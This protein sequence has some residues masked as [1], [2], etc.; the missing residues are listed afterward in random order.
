MKNLT[1]RQ[2]MII[3]VILACLSLAT[4]LWVNI[5]PNPILSLRL[6]LGT[7]LTIFMAF[8]LL[9]WRW[10]AWTR[11]RTQQQTRQ[12]IQ[13]QT[14]TDRRRFLHRLDHE[15]KNPLTT[16]RV[17]VANLRS[18]PDKQ[19]SHHA[20]TTIENE[21]L[22]LSTFIGDLRKLADLEVRPL[23]QSQV[24][25]EKLLQEVV[26]LAEEQPEAKDRQLVLHPF[27]QAPGPLP[28]IVGDHDLLFLALFNL[29]TN[30]LKFT[31]PGDRIEVRASEDGTRV[32]LE[33]ADTGIGIPEIDMPHVW[34]ELYRGQEAGATP[35][36]GLGLALVK[37][38]IERHGGQV[39]L[40]S[41]EAQGTVVTI[42]LPA[43][44]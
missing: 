1:R 24:I 12:N 42:Q 41:P 18:T 21:T 2:A 25:V 7:V 34:E 23:E 10:L 26:E 40:R 44:G 16:I 15:L 28:P 36:S 19:T 33:V 20:L 38:I 32:R 6:D 43:A 39:A 29:L 14:T 9:E 31:Q 22:R 27:P 35:G 4:L 37:I 3:L 17:G 5:L 30:A 11:Y 13:A 8:G